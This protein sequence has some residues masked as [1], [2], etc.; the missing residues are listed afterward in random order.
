[1]S[2]S[3]PY[4]GMT[5]LPIAALQYRD[6]GDPLDAEERL[7]ESEHRNGRG[8]KRRA[9]IEMSE[10]DFAARIRH[11]RADAI[12]QVEQKLRQEIEQKVVA[13]RVPVATAVKEF[14]KERDEYFARV[15]A[16][17]VQLSMSI[18]AKILHRE[19]QVDPMLVA[20]LV[21]I[22]VEK[23]REDSS[24]TVRVGAGRSAAWQQYFAGF[25]SLIRVEVAED[26]QLS[27]QDCILE[28]HLGSANFGLDTQ[29]KE[30]EQGFF[31]LLALRPPAR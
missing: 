1:M 24:V 30:V 2:Y 15:E 14:A 21:R 22:A 26:P 11:E 9:E 23:M 16:E 13:A 12:A 4:S 20:T 25:P 19:A 8:G 31:D 3:A 7:A 28:T 29:L 6:I 17:V 10:A 5:P 18:A 27:E